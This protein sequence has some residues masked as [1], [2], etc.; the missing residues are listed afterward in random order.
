MEATLHVGFVRLPVH[1]GLAHQRILSDRLALLIPRG[2]SHR[3]T[4][5]DVEAIRKLPFLLLRRARAPGLFDHI[6]RFC[7]L[8]DFEPN[9]I[10]YAN[11]SLTILSLVGAEV[12]ISLMHESALRN[13]GESVVH[14]PIDDP[15]AGWDVGIA[16]RNDE[17]DPVIGK[18]VELVS[19]L[20]PDFQ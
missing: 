20:A 2:F 17:P 3:I 12:G 5:F 9:V 19:A 7:T 11:E 13:P 4:N 1:E 18:F 16:W 8:H 14:L 10:Q 6:A 15:R